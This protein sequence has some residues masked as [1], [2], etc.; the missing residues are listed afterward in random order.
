MDH[1]GEIAAHDLT[2]IVLFGMNVVSLAG[3]ALMGITLTMRRQGGVRSWLAFL[4]M[5]VGTVLLLLGLHLAPPA[6]P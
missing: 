2:K 1:G 5:A 4:L 6:T 3:F